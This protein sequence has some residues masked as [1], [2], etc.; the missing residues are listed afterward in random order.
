MRVEPA[1]GA[2]I[3]Y[4]F[5]RRQAPQRERVCHAGEGLHGLVRQRVYLAGLVAEAT[6]Q[7]PAGV[8]VEAGAGVKGHV[9]VLAA[10]LLAQRVRVDRQI[11]CHDTP[12]SPATMGRPT[13]FH[14]G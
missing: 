4:L 1:A 8:E 11:L 13:R 12:P 6:S 9:P 14:S 5:A 2:D 10:D 3:Y 7:S